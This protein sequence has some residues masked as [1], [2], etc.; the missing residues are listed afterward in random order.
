MEEKE[1]R[2]YI[3]SGDTT[4][5]SEFTSDDIMDCAIDQLE[6][7]S[8][9][10]MLMQV[11]DGLNNDTLSDQNWYILFHKDDYMTVLS[12]LPTQMIDPE[13]EDKPDGHW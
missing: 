3:L 1:Y 2:M 8:I 13:V 5:D 11:I 6:S 9:S 12:N 7:D 4:L 10:E